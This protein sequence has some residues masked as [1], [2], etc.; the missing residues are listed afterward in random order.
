MKDKSFTHDLTDEELISIIQ[1]G[2]IM[3]KPIMERPEGYQEPLRKL[4]DE[5][6]VS[7]TLVNQLLI[8]GTIARECVARGIRVSYSN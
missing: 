7:I 4:M 6:G 1:C 2:D 5:I 8:I 3:N